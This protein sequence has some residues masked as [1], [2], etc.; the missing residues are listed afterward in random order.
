MA[1]ASQAEPST[2]ADV[3]RVGAQLNEFTTRQQFADFFSNILTHEKM[4]EDI[5]VYK[6]LAFTFL[7]ESQSVLHSSHF[8]AMRSVGEGI[9]KKENVTNP[10]VLSLIGL[11]NPPKHSIP[12]EKYIFSESRLPEALVEKTFSFLRFDEL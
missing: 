8:N 5:S 7:K 3:L 9:N 11:P 1:S 10:L 6:T 4:P 12:A 2:L